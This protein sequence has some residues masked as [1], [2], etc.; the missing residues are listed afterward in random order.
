[1]ETAVHIGVNVEKETV[2]TVTASIKE[3]L[4]ANA[5]QKTI[6]HALTVFSSMAKVENVNISDV[7]VMGDRKQE[8]NI[9]SDSDQ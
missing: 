6:R 8:I 4:S 9:T 2:E 5:D 7:N 1:M 3:I